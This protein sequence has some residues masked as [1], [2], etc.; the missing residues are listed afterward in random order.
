LILLNKN[1]QESKKTRGYFKQ[2]FFIKQPFS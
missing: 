2:I 1:D